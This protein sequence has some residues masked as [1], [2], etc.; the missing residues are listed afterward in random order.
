MRGLGW[1]DAGIQAGGALWSGLMYCVTSSFSPEM[2][3]YFTAVLMMRSL[4]RSSMLHN[5]ARLTKL[6]VDLIRGVLQI[7]LSAPGKAAAVKTK[8]KGKAA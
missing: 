3:A 8:A 4:C 5:P 7:G 2:A 1:L 6:H